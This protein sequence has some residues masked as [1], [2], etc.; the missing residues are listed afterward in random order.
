MTLWATEQMAVS[1]RVRITDVAARAG[2]GVGTV[3][4]VLNGSPQVREST[5]TRVLEVIEQIR[6]RPSRLAAGL[7]RGSPASVAIVVPFLTRPSV[8]A[9]LAGVIEVLDAAGYDTIVCNVETPAQRDRQTRMLA[10]GHRAAGVVVISLRLSAAQF[11]E[12]AEAGVH[13]VLVDVPF[14][15]VPHTVVDDVH[16]GMLATNYLISLG[17]RRIGFIG[18]T[19]DGGLGFSS[20]LDRLRGYRRALAMAGAP[21]DPALVCRGPRGSGAAADMAMGLLRLPEPPTAIFAASDTQAMGVLS[22]AEA[23]GRQVPGELSVIG[24][25]DIEMAALVGLSTV[26]Q[27]LRES[28]A[29]GAARLCTLLHGGSVRPLRETLPLEVVARRSTAAPRAVAIA[30]VQR[31]AG[32]GTAVSSRTTWQTSRSCG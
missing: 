24:F 30:A 19:G 23:A 15:G 12:L 22:A 1:K 31:R 3:S 11:A 4:R 10:A 17:H 2:V 13:V 7:S 16:G 21:V 5:R 8:V 18:D 9:R 32:K 6:Y 25:D 27:P 20:T 28:G 29:R 14:R 26:R